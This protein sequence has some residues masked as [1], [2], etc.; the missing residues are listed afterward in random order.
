MNNERCRRP[1]LLRF[2]RARRTNGGATAT[3]AHPRP[4]FGEDL[5]KVCGA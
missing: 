2:C 1:P 4:I 3:P 5:A